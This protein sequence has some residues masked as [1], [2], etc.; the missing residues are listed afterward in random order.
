MLNEDPTVVTAKYVAK[1][2]Q[3]EKKGTKTEH[4]GATGKSVYQPK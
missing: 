1:A 3:P 4:K 2:T